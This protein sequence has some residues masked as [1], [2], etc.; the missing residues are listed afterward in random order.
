MSYDA[1]GRL[2]HRRL[3]FVSPRKAMNVPYDLRPLPPFC[4]RWTGVDGRVRDVTGPTG[5]RWGAGRS[6][7]GRE[8][9]ETPGQ[10]AG[11][12]LER[13]GTEGLRERWGTATGSGVRAVWAR[14]QSPRLPGRPRVGLWGVFTSRLEEWGKYGGCEAQSPLTGPGPPGALEFGCRSFD[15]RGDSPDVPDGLTCATPVP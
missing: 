8:K 6:V 1:L 2:G 4:G 9:P 5:D 13:C 7:S 12:M 3:G 10:G 15:P 11:T 14:G